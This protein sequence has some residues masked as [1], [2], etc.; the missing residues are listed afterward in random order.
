MLLRPTWQGVSSMKQYSLQTIC[1]QT[2]MSSAKSLTDIIHSAW[3]ILAQV[4]QWHCNDGVCNHTR[5][6]IIVKH[7][8]SWILLTS[9]HRQHWCHCQMAWVPGLPSTGGS[10]H[11]GPSFCH[12]LA[13]PGLGLYLSQVPRFS[14]SRCKG[15]ARMSFWALGKTNGNA[16]NITACT[17]PWMQSVIPHSTNSSIVHSNVPYG[18]FV[19]WLAWTLMQSYTYKSWQPHVN[20]TQ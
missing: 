15:W 2:S 8:R 5:I 9:L 12:S 3:A 7:L 10:S 17:P 19:I 18:T 4:V 6:I 11:L 1:H 16:E 13:C 14:A 20:S